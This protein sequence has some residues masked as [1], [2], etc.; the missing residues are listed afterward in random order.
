M[1]LD[2]M[3]V[4]LFSSRDEMVFNAYLYLEL[5]N[6]K[7]DA[8]LLHIWIYCLCPRWVSHT[9]HIDELFLHNLNWVQ[10]EAATPDA[11]FEAN[12]EHYVLDVGRYKYWDSTDECHAAGLWHIDIVWLQDASFCWDSIVCT[13]YKESWVFEH[14][15]FECYYKVN[16][17]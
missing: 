8:C 9:W 12:N 6:I 2:L 14:H 13:Q 5:H 4:Y 15:Y 16:T 7:W 17:V 3:A 1:N 10:R 11:C